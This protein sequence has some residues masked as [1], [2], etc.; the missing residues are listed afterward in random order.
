MMM[1]KMNDHEGPSTI[2]VCDGCKHYS[3]CD[4]TCSHGIAML[5]TAGTV[6]VVRRDED[7]RIMDLAPVDCPAQN[8]EHSSIEHAECLAR[9]SITQRNDDS[10]LMFA[11]FEKQIQIRYVL[12]M[13]QKLHDNPRGS[14]I[15]WQWAL[16]EAMFVMKDLEKEMR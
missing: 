15:T 2:H 4:S 9:D 8:V 12:E 10:N 6:E 1:K 11:K 16:E 3:S 14:T 13:L 7:N 5:L